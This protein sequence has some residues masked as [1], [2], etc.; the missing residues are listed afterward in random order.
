MAVPLDTSD[1]DTFRAWCRLFGPRVGW[2]KVG[3]EAFV[4]WGPP[5]VEEAARHAPVFLDLKLHDIPNTVAGAVAAA[6]DLGA[7]LLTVH[8]G[9]GPAMLAAAQQ[10]AG[11]LGLLAVTL[12]THLDDPALEALDLAGA[13][14]DRVKRWAALAD[15]A[16]C[17]GVVCS[18]RELPRLRATHPRPFL[19]V[20]PGIR[21]RGAAGHDQRRVATP[22]EALDAGSDV[23]VIGRPLTRAADP[24]AAL[25]ELERELA[26][27]D[28]AR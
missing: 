5:A 23:L 1:R 15:D 4:R 3:L 2:L 20:T 12:L 7:G 11:E 25:D 8:A 18:P 22:A 27:P 17:A 24:G 28:S 16:G 21:P 14:E 9:G 10:A 26:R 6:R 13:A 19:L